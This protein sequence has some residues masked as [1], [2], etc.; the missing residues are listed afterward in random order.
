MRYLFGIFSIVLMILS[1]EEKVLSLGKHGSVR[2]MFDQEKLIQIDRLDVNGEEM[3]SH[4]Y[5]YGEDGRLSSEDLIGGLGKVIHDGDKVISPFG[6]EV[7]EYDENH[8]LIK[9][10]LNGVSKEYIYNE[11]NQIV[12]GD[13]EQ[14]FLYDSF[15]NVAQRGEDQFIY[16]DDNNLSKVITPDC[17]IEYSYDRF[18]RR[19]SRTINE[20][21]EYYIYFG[22]NEMAIFD[23]NSQIKELRIPGL[24]THKDILRP[25]AIETNDAIYAPIH[26]VQGNIIRLINI[27]NREV[28]MTHSEDPFGRDLS[29]DVPTSWIFAGKC[30]DKEAG[31]V[32]FGRRYYSPDLKQWLTPDPMEQGSNLYQYCL[33]NPFAYCDPNGEWAIPLLSIA[34]GAGATITA[35]IWAPY[36]IAAAAGATVGYWGY[37]AYDHWQESKKDEPPF[38]GK[39]LGTDPTK[40][41]GEGFVW[42]GKGNPKSGRGN[43]YNPKTEEKLHP[44]LKHP[45]PKGPHWGYKDP[46]GQEYDLFLDGNWK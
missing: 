18:G 9:H 17:V 30:Y 24:S 39:E 44:D 25:I 20:E 34:W 13:V 45:E 41:P 42:K 23:R 19:V 36:A 22:N 10:T 12:A 27:S 5:H 3:Y 26:D 8:N 32:Y 15:G 37:K 38:N 6:L 28:T 16:D 29:D 4:S 35:P 2:Y 11:L 7:C 1:A 21:T 46:N 33:D 40:C 43:W 31:L 14:L